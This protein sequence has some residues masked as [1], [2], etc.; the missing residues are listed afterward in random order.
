MKI[1]I[2]YFYMIRFFKP[3]QIPISTAIWDPKWYHD[4]KKENYTFKDKNGVWNG[5]YYLPLAPGES[6]EGLC[7]GVDKC[8]SG[9]D[10]NNCKFLREYKKQLDNIDFDKMIL[11]F[12]N[13]CNKIERTEN[14]KEKYDC[15]PEIILIVY[16]TPN[17]P[18][19][20]RASI[21]NL[22]KQHGIDVEEFK[23]D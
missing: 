5:F 7:N 14:L 11:F 3:Y 2:S 9:K 19:S 18:C 4:F 16:E 17:N 8:N 23:K 12:K 1:K 13:L 22:F 6:C 15:E 21:I 20:E 10:P